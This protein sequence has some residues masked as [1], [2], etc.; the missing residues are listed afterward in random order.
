MSFSELHQIWAGFGRIEDGP[1]GRGDSRHHV[2]RV[3]MKKRTGV[4]LEISEEHTSTSAVTT[5]RNIAR[6]VRCSVWSFRVAHISEMQ[7]CFMQWC[8]IRVASYLTICTLFFSFTYRLHYFNDI[9]H[10][11]RFN[12]PNINFNALGA[13]EIK[14]VHHI[15]KNKN[16]LTQAHRVTGSL[17][18]HQLASDDTS[19]TR[20]ISHDEWP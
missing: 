16:V 18:Y 4:S 7:S 9:M 11:L 10:H 15:L 12:N 3:N 19:K 20:K 1:V 13:R 14:K 17:A 5:H 2:R 8:A 6:N